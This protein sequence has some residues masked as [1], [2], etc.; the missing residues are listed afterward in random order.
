MN[1]EDSQPLDSK[2]RHDEP[3]PP[4][5]PPFACVDWAPLHWPA[6]CHSR[7]AHRPP[8]QSPFDQTL[9]CLPPLCQQPPHLRDD[10]WASDREYFHLF[11]LIPCKWLIELHCT[12]FR[13]KL[14]IL[15]HRM[16]CNLTLNWSPYTHMC[17]NVPQFWLQ[18]S[19]AFSAGLSD[20]WWSQKW[21]WRS[22]QEV[23][24]TNLT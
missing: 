8:P 24:I 13:C 2:A 23:R 1:R 22:T 7:R 19:H 18:I 21:G 6:E 15:T 9:D 11:Q 17:T 5:M 20:F 16:P 3:A 14:R 10:F 4:P 12:Y